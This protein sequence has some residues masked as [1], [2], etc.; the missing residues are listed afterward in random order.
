[1]P[2]QRE[3]F[4]KDYY[5]ALGVSEGASQKDITKAY[6]KLAR[7]THPDANPGSPKN[8]DSDVRFKEVSAAYDVVGDPEK[9]KEYDEVRKLGPAGAGFGGP[10]GGGAGP[11]SSGS[12]GG[13]RAED[14]G[15]LFGGLFGR[16]RNRSPGGGG[17]ASA[18]PRRGAD[19]Q[20]NLTMDFEDAVHGITTS[21]SLTSEATCPTCAGSGA[22]PGTAPRTCPVCDGRG[23]V[24]EDQ[25]LFSFSSP[26]R[27]CGGRGVIVE[28]P[29]RT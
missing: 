14:L 21:L 17:G 11:F 20:A 16:G 15:D 23:V 12:G 6:R 13:F 5:A 28:H 24:E 3:W 1:M 7:E 18:G 29:C 26:C 19:L 27:N 4:E 10:G 9:R 25:G 22:E 8:P 2:P